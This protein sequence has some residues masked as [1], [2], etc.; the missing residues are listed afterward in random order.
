VGAAVSA[1]VDKQYQAIPTKYN[2]CQFRSRLEA[3]WAAFFDFCGWP[4]E[5]EPFDLPGWIPDFAL[6]FR[7]PVLVEVKPALDTSELFD[8]A[9]K[10][11]EGSGWNGDVVVLGSTPLLKNTDFE[12]FGAPWHQPIGLMQDESAVGWW[13][14]CGLFGCRD[15][16]HPAPYDRR[17]RPGLHSNQFSHRCRVCGDDYGSLGK[18]W[19]FKDDYLKEMWREA[20]NLV[21]WKAPA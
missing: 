9:T 7:V 19:A 5:Y 4:W 13:G 8:A 6:T 10:K 1:L 15:Q 11:V 17:W 3:R 14:T 20:G 16:S 2:G 18:K 21:Q 12:G